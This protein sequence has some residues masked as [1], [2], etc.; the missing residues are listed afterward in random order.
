MMAV[1]LIGA[2]TLG[3]NSQSLIQNQIDDEFQA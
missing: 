1:T 2:M 3:Q